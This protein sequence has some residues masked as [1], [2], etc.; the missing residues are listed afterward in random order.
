MNVYQI[1]KAEDKM[2][3]WKL[4]A[5]LMSIFKLQD[6]DTVTLNYGSKSA[7]AIVKSFQSEQ[8]PQREKDIGISPDIKSALGLSY[9]TKLH[10][11]QEGNKSF[12][13]GPIIGILT[14]SSH[15]PKRLDYYKTYFYMNTNGTLLYIFGSKGLNQKQRTISG[16]TYDINKKTW[17]KGEFPFPDAVIDRCYPNNYSSHAMLA[18]V[19]GPGRIFNKKTMITKIDFAKVLAANK[20]L[21]TYIPETKV[22]KTISDLDNFFDKYRHIYL[23]PSNAMKGKGIISIQKTPKGKYEC[24]YTSENKDVTKSVDSLSEVSDIL[25]KITK[26]KV[27]YIIQQA[28]D[29]MQYEGGPFSLRVSPVKNGKGQ[30]KVIGILVLGSLGARHVTNFS[31]GGAAIPLSKLF[32]VISNHISHTKNDFLK[33]L[34]DLA[35]KTAMALDEKF[36]PLGEL[37]VDFVID[38]KGKPWLLEANGNPAKIAAFLQSDYPSWRTQVYQYPLDYAC[39]LA[40]FQTHN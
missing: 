11:K 22:M 35:V 32:T 34:E 5:K 23:K 16:Y 26:H 40:G 18:K 3:I 10:I 27:K 9:D 19:I 1:F 8:R 13:F 20:Y 7:A 24:R 39:H 12:R 28:V 33:L 15:I 21:R 25:K 36:G 37:G 17:T 30:W 29:C 6:N 2:K 31:S 4:P 14:F 38:K